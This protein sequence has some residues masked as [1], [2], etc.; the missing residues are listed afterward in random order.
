MSASKQDNFEAHLERMTELLPSTPY[1]LAALIVFVV[2]WLLQLFVLLFRF[3]KASNTRQASSGEIQPVSVI[4]AARNEEKNLLENV[5]R[6]MEQDHPNFEVIVVND[7][8][9]DDTAEVLKALSLS[10]ANLKVIH[11]DEDKQQMQGKKFAI[12]LGIKAAK[13]D[14]I[15]LTDADCSPLSS[16]WITEMTRNLHGK[17]QLALGF[18]P[19]FRKPGWLNR[20]I[21]FDTLMI[22]CQYLGFAKAGKPY[23]GVGRNLAYHKDLFFKVGGFKNHYSIASGD[24]DLFVNQVATSGNSIIVS[25]PESQMG[26]EPK[27]TWSSWFTQKRRHFSTSGMYRPAHKL[28]LLNWP[29]SFVLL[30]LS[31]AACVFFHIYPLVIIGMLAARYLVQVL[32]LHRVSSK[33]SVSSDVAWLAPILEIQLHALNLGLYFINLLRKPK[34]WN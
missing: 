5:P 33:L 24:D 21:R 27:T 20:I 13:H 7:S 1:F 29:L 34:K 9:W 12:T 31:A 3:L 22:A 10:Y 16:G 11:I 30:W 14:I 25:S 4:I 15:L 19:Y 6:I 17:K 8:S 28:M 18:S 32:I 23:M 2:A 26:S